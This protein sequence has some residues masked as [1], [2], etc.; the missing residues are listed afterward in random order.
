MG[1]KAI[2]KASQYWSWAV[3]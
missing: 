1:L 2:R 3:G